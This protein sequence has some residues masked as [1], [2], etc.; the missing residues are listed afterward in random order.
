M[1]KYNILAQ[2]DK[3]HVNLSLWHSCC[4]A[5]KVLVRG[6]AFPLLSYFCHVITHGLQLH[7]GTH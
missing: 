2:A 7:G 1:P 6:C 5:W 4:Q 3:K